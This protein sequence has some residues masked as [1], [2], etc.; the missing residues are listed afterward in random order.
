MKLERQKGALR[1]LE[2][3]L[4]SGV[5]RNENQEIPLTS[6]DEKRIKREINIL[7]ERTK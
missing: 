1:R 4:E 3:Q 7:K 5:K 2:A 6:A